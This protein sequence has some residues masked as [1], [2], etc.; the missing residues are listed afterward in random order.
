MHF[1][2]IYISFRKSSDQRVRGQRMR[3]D[4][5]LE[6]ALTQDGELGR[7]RCRRWVRSARQGGLCILLYL[8]RLVWHQPC[9]SGG[10]RDLT[11]EE[12]ECQDQRVE[13]FP[14]GGAR[15]ERECGAHRLERT[16][17]ARGSGK[18]TDAVIECPLG[19]DMSIF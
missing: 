18:R 14:F 5:L 3:I 15:H 1:Y 6:P 2:S 17:Q 11:D 12:R 10:E 16:Q 13:V 19:T 8:M 7:L 9:G 4:L